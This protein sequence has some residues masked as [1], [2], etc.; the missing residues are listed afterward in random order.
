MEGGP[1]E[2]DHIY[3][4]QIMMCRFCGKESE[5]PEHYRVWRD[6]NIAKWRKYREDNHIFI[7]P[8]KGAPGYKCDSC[9]TVIPEGYLHVCAHQDD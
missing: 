1:E 2:C 7:P 9:G 3:D 5:G 4:T 8:C 6:K